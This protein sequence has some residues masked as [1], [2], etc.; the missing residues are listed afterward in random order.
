MEAAM[1]PL[2]SRSRLE[3]SKLAQKKRTVAEKMRQ[4]VVRQQF[5]EKRENLS[6]MAKWDEKKK[7]LI[8]YWDDGDG[9]RQSKVL[10]A[11]PAVSDMTLKD[12][13]VS[14]AK[15][16]WVDES[17]TEIVAGLAVVPEAR[18]SSAADGRSRSGDPKARGPS[19]AAR[20][21]RLCRFCSA[22]TASS[23]GAEGRPMLLGLKVGLGGGDCASA[24]A[25][26]GCA[27]LNGTATPPLITEDE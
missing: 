6:R 5:E 21:L 2:E 9:K 20:A 15:E 10:S 3:K 22:S 17:C 12:F 13:V 27:T 25:F 14:R 26:S 24:M 19:A 11:I 7:C 1:P 23:S 4:R 8:V 16:N 18:S